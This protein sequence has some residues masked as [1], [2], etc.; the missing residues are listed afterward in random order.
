MFYIFGVHNIYPILVFFEQ[1]LIKLELDN[2]ILTPCNGYLF[3]LVS[4]I[5]QG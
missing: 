2:Q 4:R 3:D 1:K 5:L